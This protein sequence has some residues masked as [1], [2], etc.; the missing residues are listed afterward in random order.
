MKLIHDTNIYNMK[1][2]VLTNESIL[3]TRLW[4]IDTFKKVTLNK[5]VFISKNSIIIDEFFPS[6]IET[7]PSQGVRLIKTK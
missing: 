1:Y 4:D 6:Y 7:F 5:L 3:V 2:Q